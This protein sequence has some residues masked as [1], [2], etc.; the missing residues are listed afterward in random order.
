MRSSDTRRAAGA[1][2]LAGLV[3]VVALAGC[4]GSPRSQLNSE[5][6]DREDELASCEAS[7]CAEEVAVL[8]AA[9]GELPGVVK[10]LEARYR[11]KQITDGASVRGELLVEAG[12]DCRSLEVSAAELG[13][14]SAV[15]PLSSVSFGCATAGSEP[16]K[17]DAGYLST[18][19]RPTSE[20]QLEDWGDRGTLEPSG[21][22]A[23]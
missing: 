17:R 19:V 2:S 5:L 1:L 4:A 9:I 20:A 3:G 10:V 13:W 21:A 22:G 15:S 23:P 14:R 11:E 7:E 16:S 18:R 6:A 8:V 12:V